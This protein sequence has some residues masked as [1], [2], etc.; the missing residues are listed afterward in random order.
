MTEDERV[1]AH[2]AFLLEKGFTFERDYNKGTDKTCTQ[3]YRFKKDGA[4]YL[5]YRV[6][7]ERER[8]LFVLAAGERK[9]PSPERKYAA[10]VRSWKLK[11]LFKKGEAW[12]LAA[13]LCK[14]EWECTGKVFGIQ[15]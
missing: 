4:N 6:L 5:E 2:F 1:Q 14:R 10:L 7:S 11:H 13:L 15:V 3:I 9:F 8:N 12:E